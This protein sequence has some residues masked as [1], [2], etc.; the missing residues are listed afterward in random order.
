MPKAIALPINI[1]VIV[2]V[3]TVVMLGLVGVYGVGYNPFSS[4]MGAESAKNNAC[5]QLVFGGC[6]ANTSDIKVNYSSATNL[7]DL[8]KNVFGRSDEKSCKQLC[9]CVGTVTTGG[10][11]LGDFSVSVVPVSSTITVGSS[12]TPA[13]SVGGVS[14]AAV[15]LSIT[16]CPTGATCQ[17]VPNAGVPPFSSTLTITNAAV[18]GPYAMTITGTNVT[19]TKTTSYS[20][21]VNPVGCA[22]SD[23]TSCNSCSNV[24]KPKWCDSSGNLISNQCNAPHNCPCPVALPSCNA[25]TGVCSAAACT[26]SDGTICNSCSSNKPKYCTVLKYLVDYCSYCGCPLG[27]SCNADGSCSGAV[28]CSW[29][30]SFCG[31][32]PGCVLCCYDV[33]SVPLYELVCGPAGCTGGGCVAGTRMCST[34]NC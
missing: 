23:G 27:Q 12:A 2:A 6:K 30:Q 14:P 25:G 13:V 8:C 26:C 19:R 4:A 28:A 31:D 7:F 9:G 1:L 24:N 11:P 15:T 32:E 29:L 20:L 3:A 18:G 16:G 33:F 10:T 34:T 21:K 17:F 22:C 5:R